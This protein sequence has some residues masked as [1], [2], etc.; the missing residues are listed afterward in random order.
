VVQNAFPYPEPFSADYECDRL[1][2]QTEPAL[3]IALLYLVSCIDVE[4][5]QNK[6]KTL[7]NVKNVTIKSVKTF[8]IYGKLMYCM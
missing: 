7:Q 6:I 2:R 1:E 8:N 3:A 5:V 4:N